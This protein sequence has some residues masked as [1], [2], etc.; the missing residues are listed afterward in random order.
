MTATDTPSLNPAPKATQ[1]EWIG[2]AVLALPCLL[3]AMDL[4]VL[5]LAVPHLSADL[6]PTSTELLW[7]ID[8]YGFVV[9]GA[10]IPMG[11]YGDRIGRRKLLLIGAA[12]FGVAS[13]FAAF[14]GSVAQLIAARAVLG[15]AAATLAP[16]TLSLIRNMF[17]DERER[18]VAIGIWISSFS[19]GG[20][21]GPVLGGVLL[22]YFWWGSV[23]LLNVPIML[24]LLAVGPFL[25]SEY[26][27]PDAGRPDLV[28]AGLSLATTLAVIYGIKRIAESGPDAVAL[29]TIAAGIAIG[30][31]FVQRQKRLAQP[32][33]D[34]ALF[35][36]PSFTAAL[37][38]NIVAVF[39]AFGS[40]LFVAQ[41]LQLVIG[42]SPLEAGLWS[43]P[44]GIT[45][46]IGSNLTPVL[47]RHVSRVSVVTGGL[48]LTA[49]SFVVMAQVTG[50]RGDLALVVT[51]YVLMSLGMASVFTL[52]TDFIIGAAPPERAGLAA[53][54]AETS[55]EFG[56]ALG[57]AIL[58]SVVTAIYRPTVGADLPPNLPA[59]AAAAAR[60]TLGGALAAAAQLTDGLGEALVATARAAY[61]DSF[62]VI[63]II[64]AAAL[65]LAAAIAFQALRNLS[66]PA[67]T[68]DLDLPGE[69]P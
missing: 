3:Y 39:A 57:I 43:A 42:L 56:G 34:L 50:G 53:G 20:A 59:D 37:G 55:S 21:I 25:L 62:Q 48:A 69:A 27:D 51:A 11:V 40:F 36:R 63:S 14:A 7:I 4:T 58:G 22:E 61:V 45:F 15:L 47:V 10:L 2:L 46:I 17:L 18:T 30:Y 28:S 19:A 44:S 66:N 38:I 41:Y 60:D 35:R 33:I 1:R 23:F 65:A 64:S 5:N 49:A 16:S 54:M 52:T 24:L 9:A 26:R 12:F 31:V 67:P 29:A 6:G 68:P 8:I 13:I 32:F